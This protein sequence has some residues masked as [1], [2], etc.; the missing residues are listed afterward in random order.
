MNIALG[1]PDVIRFTD[2]LRDRELEQRVRVFLT[3]QNVPSLRRLVIEAR[4]GTVTL[5]GRVPTFYEKQLSQLC[6]RRVTGVRRL[7]D[8]MVVEQTEPSNGHQQ[9]SV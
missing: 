7:V 9:I 4:N 6:K 2:E 1:V 5:R 3:G 8:Q